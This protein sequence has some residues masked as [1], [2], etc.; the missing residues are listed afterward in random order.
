MLAHW[1]HISCILT[2]ISSTQTGRNTYDNE[3]HYSLYARIWGAGSLQFTLVLFFIL[4]S[5]P[6]FSRSRSFI[7]F[8]TAAIFPRSVNIP[9]FL[10][11]SLQ[12]YMIVMLQRICRCE[13]RETYGENKGETFY[14][15][16]TFNVRLRNVA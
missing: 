12:R 9:P 16:Y 7:V 3:C 2:N 14:Y 4:P 1:L 8:S 11:S 5:Q 13:R 15:F 10:T 6:S